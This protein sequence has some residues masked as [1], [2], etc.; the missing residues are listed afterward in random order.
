MQVQVLVDRLEG[1]VVGRDFFRNGV[2]ERSLDGGEARDESEG[3]DGGNEET[4]HDL[5]LGSSLRIRPSS[6]ASVCSFSRWLG[7]GCLS[8]GELFCCFTKSAVPCA[9][10]RSRKSVFTL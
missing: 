2:F 5:D 10:A 4:F 3:E 9:S 6:M 7:A 1:R 8:A